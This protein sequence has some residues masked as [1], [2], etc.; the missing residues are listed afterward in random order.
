MA[1]RSLGNGSSEAEAPS[2]QPKTREVL[3]GNPAPDE[4][5]R[6]RAYEIYLERGE[7]PGG[8][9]DDWLQAEREL[10]QGVIWLAQA[11]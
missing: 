5:I 6:R 7:H 2:A 11:S 8:E 10:E 4:E 9:L 3:V 1:S